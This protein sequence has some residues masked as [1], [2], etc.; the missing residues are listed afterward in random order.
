MADKAVTEKLYLIKRRR[1]FIFIIMTS[2]I[3]IAILKKCTSLVSELVVFFVFGGGILAMMPFMLLMS[4][5]T[6][7]K[8][9]DNYFGGLPPRIV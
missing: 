6:C 5:I 9:N 8:C 7:Q 1:I 4:M 2:L 3:A